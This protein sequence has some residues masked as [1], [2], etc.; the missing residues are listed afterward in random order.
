MQLSSNIVARVVS[1]AVFQNYFEVRN[2]VI[3]KVKVLCCLHSFTTSF[4]KT[5][6]YAF[7]GFPA[8]SPLMGAFG[9]SIVEDNA[10]KSFMGASPIVGSSERPSVAMIARV[11]AYQ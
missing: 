6:K 5:F 1:N 2:I 4:Q 10:S 8:E 9:C 3:V 11:I 7:Q